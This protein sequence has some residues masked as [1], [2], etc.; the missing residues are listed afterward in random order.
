MMCHKKFDLYLHIT[1]VHIT[2]RVAHFPMHTVTQLKPST[3][4]GTA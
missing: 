3:K 2:I 4:M 1:D